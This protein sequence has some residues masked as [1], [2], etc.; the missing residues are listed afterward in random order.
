MHSIVDIGLVVLVVYMG[1][2]EQDGENI[3]CMARIFFRSRVDMNIV[4]HQSGCRGSAKRREKIVG[5]KYFHR[6]LDRF[7]TE[8]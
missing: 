3:T 7:F 2:W 4:L 6:F 8:K 1:H 5:N